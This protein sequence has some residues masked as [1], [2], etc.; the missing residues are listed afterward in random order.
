MSTEESFEIRILLKGS[1]DIEKFNIVK[2][3]YKTDGNAKVFRLLL[4]DKYQEIKKLK[5][6]SP[7]R[8]EEIES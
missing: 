7:L 6:Q 5:L 2:E 8:E 3:W 4:N 1:G